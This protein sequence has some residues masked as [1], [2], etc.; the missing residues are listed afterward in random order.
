MLRLLR[1]LALLALVAAL[2]ACGPARTSV[3]P[4]TLSLQQMQ[5]QPNGLWRLTV[6]IQNNSY[7]GMD[8]KSI[9]GTLQ[10]ADGIPVRLHGSFDRDIPAFAGDVTTLD[11]LPTP[12]MSSALA[13][14][15]AKGSAGSLP[16]T[17]AGTVHC[18][19]DL[20]DRP[21]DKN[22]RDF[23]FQHRDALSPVPGIAHTFR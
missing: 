17:M 1:C 22:P 13:A 18:L 23:P 11:V 8:F 16:Y 12:A 10:V 6:R 15:A 2:A 9:D 20:A 5:V 14:V 19:P 4:P 3:F 21:D 7:G